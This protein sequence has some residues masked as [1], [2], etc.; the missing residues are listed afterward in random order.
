MP[1]YAFSYILGALFRSF[2]TSSSSSSTPKTNINS[3]LHWTSNNSIVLLKT[4]L[5][6]GFRDALSVRI[7]I[8]TIFITFALQKM[9]HNIELI[10]MSQCNR[11]LDSASERL[12]WIRA[13]RFTTEQSYA[14]D[15]NC[16]IDVKHMSTSQAYC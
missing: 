15:F 14:V 12:G 3:T 10:K 4:S 9:Y 1:K 13:R 11:T 7:Y 16:F 6:C 2:L 8:S 5:Y